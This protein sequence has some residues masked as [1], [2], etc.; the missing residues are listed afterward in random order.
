MNIEQVKM[1]A[2][3]YKIPVNQLEYGGRLFFQFPF[4]RALMDEIK[5]L[6]GSRWEGSYADNPARC[7]P[8]VAKAFGQDKLWSVIKSQHNAFQLAYLRGENPYA[9]YERDLIDVVINPRPNGLSPRE[10]QVELV[11]IFLT[12]RRVIAAYEQGVGKSL[13]AIIAAELAGVQK[14]WWVS[15]K[16]GVRAVRRELQFWDA[17]IRPELMTYEALL[18]RI[19]G[20]REG[21]EIPQLIILDEAHKVKT[22]TAQ[23]S[24]AA[25]N[26]ADMI[27]AMY[28]NDAYIWE[29]TGTP[30]PK[31]PTDWWHL[32]RIACPGFLREGTFEKFRNRLA[33]IVNKENQ[34]TGGVY[35]SMVTWK[36]DD[37]K[38]SICGHKQETHGLD[39]SIK[40]HDFTKADNEITKLYRRMRGLVWV[41]FKKDC[42]ELPDKIYRIVKCKPSG[43]MLRSAKLLSARAK[44]VIEKITLLRELSDGFQYREIEGPEITCPVCNGAR[45]LKDFRND[46]GESYCEQFELVGDDYVPVPRPADF[47]ECDVDCYECDGTGKTNRI[48]REAAQIDTPK[49]EALKDIL[50]D[51]EECGRLVVYAGFTGSIDRV[52]QIAQ[53]EGWSTIRADGRGWLCQDAKGQRLAE[54]PLALFQDKVDEHPKVCFIG[55]PESAGEGITLTKSPTIVYWS[56]DFNFKSRAQSED[57]IHRMGMDVN[58][59]ATII[60]LVCLPT[61]Q[62]ILDNLKAKKAL[63]GMTLT[64]IKW[65]EEDDERLF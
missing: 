2:G 18:K 32:C 62:M 40:P 17:K 7:P 39:T 35:P 54:E 38:C 28:M 47:V 20:F 49:E 29:M 58:R 59:G 30:A 36:D 61:D 44:R 1:R 12:Y 50:E 14:I 56:N 23:R 25:A 53:A 15:S 3:G 48:G 5:A 16:S 34:V 4:S 27:R 19:K 37:G 43:E 64:G 60:D 42:L 22:H 31:A 55:H 8:E 26:L 65:D 57:R 46:D 11:Q 51:H 45:T 24:Q 13:A 6:E 41:K 63:Q 9:W 21:D 52:V 10:H 33:I